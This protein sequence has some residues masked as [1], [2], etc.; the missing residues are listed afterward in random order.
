MPVKSRRAGALGLCMLGTLLGA[1][2]AA[3]EAAQETTPPAETANANQDP[4]ARGAYLVSFGGCNDCHSP[5]VMTA[6]G[7]VPDS[8]RI[9]SGHRAGTDLPAIPAGAIGPEGWGALTNQEFTAWAGPWGVSFAANLTPDATG[10]GS[11][12]EEQFIQTMRTGKHLGAGRALLPPMPWF[13]LAGLTDE[14]LRAIFAYLRSLQPVP[15]A[16]PAPIPP[17][18]PP[19]GR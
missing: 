11:W 19:A 10:L 6:A 18:N 12:T 16:V 9:L 2:C 13:G 14:D 5:K 1:A 15:N 8:T 7:P 17:A 3:E 4:L